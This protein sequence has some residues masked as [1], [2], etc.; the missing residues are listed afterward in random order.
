MGYTTQFKGVLKFAQ[1]LS[2]EQLKA[3]NEVLGEDCDKLKAFQLPEEDY[4][5]MQ[6]EV[7]K[8]MSGIRWDGGEKF[9]YADNALNLLLRYMREQ[10]PEFSLTGELMAQGEEVGDLWKIVMEDGVATRKDMTPSGTKITCPECDHTFYHGHVTGLN[11]R[12]KDDGRTH[13]LRFWR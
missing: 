13:E 9:Y 8:D 2:I 5:Y 12:E 6:Y 4:S 10:F 11:G 7:T 3:L 1:P